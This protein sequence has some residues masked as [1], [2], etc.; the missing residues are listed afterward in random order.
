MPGS[1]YS[2]KA[3]A[4]GR[5]P[6]LA[7]ALEARGDDNAEW[8]IHTPVFDGPLDLL[9]YLVRRDGVNI[10][11]ISLSGI[12]DSYLAYIDRMRELNLSIAA[13]YLVTAA[14]LVHL[15]SLELLPRRPTPVDEEQEDPK[16]ELARQLEEYARLKDAAAQLDARPWLGRDE[17]SRE[18]LD[19]DGPEERW[20]S[21]VDA[22]GLLDRF[23]SLLVKAAEPEPV[24]Q[25]E[26]PGPDFRACCALV[27]RALDAGDGKVEITRLLRTLGTRAERVATFIAVLEMVRLRW[28]DIEQA[29]HAGPVQV[30]RKVPSE[31]M[32]LDF[33][34]GYVER[35][36]PV[37][38]KPA[39]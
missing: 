2:A 30:T 24:F 36:E 29:R 11:E 39:P 16:L 4:Q 38:V 20:A 35:P 37:P 15:K 26:E 14:T 23:Y 10:R 7:L 9:L 3:S 22:F 31:R 27:V 5:A 32:D 28:L 33:V 25:M 1:P 18:P 17:F 21:P 12:A 34:V 8:T 19:V 13:D 6:Q